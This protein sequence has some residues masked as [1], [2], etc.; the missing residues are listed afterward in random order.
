MAICFDE[1]LILVV[2]FAFKT[3]SLVI[4]LTERTAGGGEIL[5][6]TTDFLA[7]I[8]NAPFG[9]ILPFASLDLL[10]KRNGMND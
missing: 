2:G 9:N 1:D 6:L 10:V 7:A 8:Y 5:D 4:L 3:G